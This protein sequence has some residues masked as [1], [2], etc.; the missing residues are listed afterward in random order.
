MWT[1]GSRLGHD[2]GEDIDS[3]TNG[4]NGSKSSYVLGG[5]INTGNTCFM[6]SVIQVS[7][8]L[9][10]FLV[11]HALTLLCYLSPSPHCNL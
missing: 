4:A 8:L 9:A 11:V 5:L 3:A 10:Y 1:S 7:C 2:D 6:N